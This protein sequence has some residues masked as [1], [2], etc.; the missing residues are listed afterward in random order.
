MTTVWSKLDIC[1][2]AFNKLNKASVA[3]FASAGEFADSAERTFDML[4]PS[5]IS[6]KSWR[7]ATKTQPLNVLINPPPVDYWAY[8]LQLP[9]DYLAALRTWPPM[10]YQIYGD[11][12]WANNNIVTLEYRALPDVTHLPAYFVHYFAILL[13]AWYAD[14]VVESATLAA[15][16]SQE[17]QVQLGEALFT[18]SQSHPIP[19]MQ[20][21]PMIQARQGIW[22]DWDRPPNN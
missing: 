4:Y 20:L 1:N 14:T 10:D 8:E 5:A 9:S 21:N 19:S 7:F 18:D 15:K 3:D 11:K 22:Y 16:L 12:M 13:A 17:A 2:F 6:G